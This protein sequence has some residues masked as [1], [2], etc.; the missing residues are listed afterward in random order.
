MSAFRLYCSFDVVHPDISAATP[1]QP[2]KP[3]MRFTFPFL[4]LS[5][6]LQ[7]ENRSITERHRLEF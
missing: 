7:T 6:S 5:L 2:I 3:I 4:S 1:I